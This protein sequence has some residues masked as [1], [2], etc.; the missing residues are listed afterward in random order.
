MT[1]VGTWR[2]AGL[3]T[4]VL[5]AAALPPSAG[6]LPREQIRNGLYS[7]EKGSRTTSGAISFRVSGRGR[8]KRVTNITYRNSCLT[9]RRAGLPLRWGSAKRLTRDRRAPGRR[10]GPRAAHRPS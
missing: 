10:P 7:Y 5:G 3:A 1:A 8:N 4:A 6:A 9:H 2:R